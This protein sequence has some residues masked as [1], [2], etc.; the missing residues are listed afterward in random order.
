MESVFNLFQDR[1][2]NKT[3]VYVSIQTSFFSTPHLLYGILT[4]HCMLHINLCSLSRLHSRNRCSCHFYW[5][6][7]S[8]VSFHWMRVLLFC[9]KWPAPP[10]DRWPPVFTCAE[11]FKISRYLLIILKCLKTFETTCFAFSYVCNFYFKVL[12]IFCIVNCFCV[13]SHVRLMNC[14]WCVLKNILCGSQL[15]IFN[16]YC[17]PQEKK[18]TY[19]LYL[20]VEF[21]S[22][23][24]N[25]L[26][27]KKM[28]S[29][30]EFL[31]GLYSVRVLTFSTIVK[32]KYLTI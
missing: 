5:E 23:W 30:W 18:V 2:E 27:F 29:L 28:F 15:W 9:K 22:A 20:Q 1:E 21:H 14:D 16:F 24:F 31:Y 26:F 12:W 32:T 13:P 6:N 3:L 25:R 8:P 4:F 11:V 7:F 19:T 17:W 10:A